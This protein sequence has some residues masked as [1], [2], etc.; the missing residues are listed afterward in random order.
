MVDGI[1]W[2][3][4]LEEAGDEVADSFDPLPEGTYDLEV[5]EARH[6]KTKTTPSKDMWAVQYKVIGGAFNNRRVFNNIVLTLDNQKALG[7]FFRNMGA[8]GL[9][10]E[11]FNTKPTNEAISTALRGRRTRGQVIQKP[12]NGETKNEI[13][14]YRAVADAATPPPAGAVAPPM[15]ATP[16]PPPAAAAPPAAAPA[17]PPAPAPEA[18]AP[19][20]P[21][22][23][24]PAPA[25][26]PPAPSE[27]AGAVPPPPPLSGL[28]F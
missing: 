6:T 18:P 3:Q 28:P 23:P 24:A 27:H 7:F 15:G 26:A 1:S 9:T 10:R 22:A 8:H 17:A 12:Y 14:G 4:L 19:A 21:P 20:A 11:F 16:P 5:V 13:K 2:D 25:P